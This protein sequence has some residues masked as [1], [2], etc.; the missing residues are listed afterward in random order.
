MFLF[1]SKVM[2]R[3]LSFPSKAQVA[4]IAGYGLVAA[5]HQWY[6][7][8][9]CHFPRSL[10]PVRENPMPKFLSQSPA[11][12]APRPVLPPVFSRF[13]KRA[14]F[15]N[16]LHFCIYGFRGKV[17]FFPPLTALH[18]DGFVLCFASFL[19]DVKRLRI[20]EGGSFIDCD[21]CFFRILYLPKAYSSEQVRSHV[22]GVVCL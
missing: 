1:S 13:L 4:F 20:L 21:D 6:R 9:G 19:F 10:F 3:F 22:Q 16:R 2:W 11:D 8:T 18:G 17:K 12:R 14:L 5:A 7:L 15:V